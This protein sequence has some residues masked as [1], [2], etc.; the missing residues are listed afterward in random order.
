[1]RRLHRIARPAERHR[2][3]DTLI[4][5]DQLAERAYLTAPARFYE[6][7]IGDVLRGGDRLSHVEEECSEVGRT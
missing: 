7:G 3:D 4:A 2:R 1:V 6:L 5:P